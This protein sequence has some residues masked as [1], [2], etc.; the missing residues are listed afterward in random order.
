MN[1]FEKKSFIIS[2]ILFF[3]VQLI[4]IGFINYK[5][6]KLQL[7]YLDTSIKKELEL[8]SYKLTC[9]NIKVDF[10]KK[11]NQP[12]LE[13][14]KT[15]SSVKVYFDIPYLKNNYLKLSIPKKIYELKRKEIIKK[16]LNKMLI[17][18]VFIIFS[19][20]LF[21]LYLLKPLKEAFKLN[22]TFIKDILHDFNTPLSSIKINLYSLKKTLPENKNIKRIET[23]IENIL[24]LQENLRNFLNANPMQKE[25]VNLK[26]LIEKEIESHKNNYPDILTEINIPDI[27]V[28]TNKC[29]LKSIL[30][31]IISN[32]FKYNKKNGKITVYLDNNNLIIEDTGIGIKNPKKV[33]E[34]YYK[35][36]ERGIGIG[37]NIAKKLSDEIKVDITVK[38][39]PQKGT[40]VFLDLK[41]IITD[42]K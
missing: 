23:G 31:N 33:F 20:I 35:E 39:K 34:R 21:T 27:S 24:K 42:K 5:E 28:H 8:C 26:D 1:K 25:T 10:E 17:E 2:F 16:L 32:A 19:S 29:A 9:K 22:E 40:K 3:T 36:N 38:S 14:I 18:I 11:H 12:L 7:H 13:L 41:N 15:D 6:Y 4:L 30:S 37:M